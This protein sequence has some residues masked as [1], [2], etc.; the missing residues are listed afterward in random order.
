MYVIIKFDS[1]NQ[2]YLPGLES[3]NQSEYF[4]NVTYPRFLSFPNSP[5]AA[6]NANETRANADL[7]MEFRVGQSGLGDDWLYAYVP[8]EGWTQVGR[9]LEVRLHSARH[10]KGS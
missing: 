10:R 6:T 9:Y 7:L 3:L 8:F 5:S 1:L 4:V 2:D